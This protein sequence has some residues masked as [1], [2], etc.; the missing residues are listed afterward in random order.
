MFGV[1]LFLYAILDYLCARFGVIHVSLQSRHAQR[2]SDALIADAQL[3][4][5]L[6]EESEQRRDAA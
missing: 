3:A 5:R 1:A 2:E 4:E 6:A